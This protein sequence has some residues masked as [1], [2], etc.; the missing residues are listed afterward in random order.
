MDTKDCKS[1][2]ICKELSC[3]LACLLANIGFVDGGLICF[4]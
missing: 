1:I 2:Y 4:E 3:V